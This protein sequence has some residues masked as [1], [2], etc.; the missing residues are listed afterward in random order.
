MKILWIA[1]T[2]VFASTAEA[3]LSDYLGP[4]V[5]SRGAGDIGQ[6]GGQPVNLRFFANLTGIYD[7]S[8]LPYSVDSQGNLVQ[9]NGLY[10]IEAGFGVYG[11]HQWRR[12]RLGLDYRGNFY[13]YNKA[14]F[15]DGTS[16]NLGLG[17]TYRKSRRLTFDLRE[18]AGTSS[19]AIGGLGFFYGAG[20]AALSSDIIN[21]PGAQLFDNRIYYLQ[22]SMAV[23]VIQSARTVY[24][25]GGDGYTVRRQAKGLA[26]LNG[27]TLRGRVQHRLSKNRSV[28]LTYEHTHF[29]F[30]P[31]FGEADIDTLMASFNSGFRRR[32]TFSVSAGAFLAEVNGL[33]EVRLDP[34]IAAVL[35][36]A[37]GIQTFYRRTI[38]PTGTASLT[39][40]L[41]RTSSVTLSYARMVTRGNGLY[42]TSRSESGSGSYTYT[43]IR[44]WNLGVNGGYTTLSG[45]GQNIRPYTLVTGG[46][47]FTYGLTRALHV[48]G[49]FDARHQQIDLAGALRTGYRVS[50][51]F[52]FSPGDVPLSLW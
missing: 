49:R 7:N 17:Y 45:I 23:N 43:G 28:G 18:I 6:R 19:R 46:A 40:Q 2:C 10:G 35:G 44:K 1:L 34:V 25:L 21:Q 38:Y 14:S 4:G 27:Y 13:H 42:L 11:T 48:T 39:G 50:M 37:T 5:L 24:T 52:A 12:A 47:G 22:T 8:L 32:W 20:A 15:Y 33:R 30:P 9:V 26:S 29:D 16:H 31:Q 36:Q 3:Q 41:N 51:G